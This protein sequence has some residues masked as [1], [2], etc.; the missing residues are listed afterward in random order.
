M[1]DHKFVIK[2]SG[3]RELTSSVPQLPYQVKEVLDNGVEIRDYP[4]QI[5]ASTQF[6]D[7]GQAFRTLSSYIFGDN[8]RGERI[9]MT[10]PV[11]IERCEYGPVMN[12]V[13][14]ERYRLQEPPQ[15]NTVRIKMRR[16]KPMSLAAISFSG[17]AD[18]ESCRQN[19]ERLLKTLADRGLEP[20]E[21]VYL[22]QYDDPRT[23]PLERRNE[24]A[25]NIEEYHP[26]F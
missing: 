10:A 3:A 8:R 25:V 6:R 26:D 21:D 19:L 24:I 14:P 20:G 5:L 22:M 12:F 11:I 2:D 18:L 9:G 16:V 23:P 1:H 4:E 17:D 15:P 7:Q 13:L